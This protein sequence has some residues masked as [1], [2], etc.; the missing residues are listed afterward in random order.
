MLDPKKPFALD[1]PRWRYVKLRVATTV[2]VRLSPEVLDT[3]LASQ[4]HPA[5]GIISGIALDTGASTYHDGKY[6]WY[7]IRLPGSDPY[8]W[9][10]KVDALIIEWGPPI[11]LLD[12]ETEL[13]MLEKSKIKEILTALLLVI[14]L[15]ASALGVTITQQ[16]GSSEATP[17]IEIIP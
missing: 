16:P 5:A 6:Y 2:N 7:P 10:A 14:S 4:L 12:E 3:N 1:D 13:P 15:L 17:T 8:V 9:I 11:N